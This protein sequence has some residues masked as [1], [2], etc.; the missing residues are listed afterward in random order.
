MAVAVGAVGAVSQGAVSRRGSVARKAEARAAFCEGREFDEGT[1][2]EG[3]HV[4]GCH[5]SV[6]NLSLSSTSTSSAQKCPAKWL[7]WPVGAGHSTCRL[8]GHATRALGWSAAGIGTGGGMALSGSGSSSTRLWHSLSSAAAPSRPAPTSF[9]QRPSGASSLSSVGT[10]CPQHRHRNTL[11]PMPQRLRS[12]HARSSCTRRAQ[13]LQ[14]WTP[15]AVK[16]GSLLAIRLSA[17]TPHTVQR[18]RSESCIGFS[19]AATSGAQTGQISSRS[20]SVVG[21]IP[22]PI[23]E[24]IFI[25]TREK[26]TA[27]AVKPFSCPTRVKRPR[28][29]RDQPPPE[30]VPRHVSCSLITRT[31][32]EQRSPQGQKRRACALPSILLLAVHLQQ[33]AFPKQEVLDLSPRS[34]AQHIAPPSS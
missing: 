8:D 6:S 17:G 28:P 32:N 18:S 25:E 3:G 4:P 2:G 15:R 10:A 5:E 29:S 7:A 26:N 19:G 27:P 23:M 21:P 9:S 16:Y 34:H 14:T 31:M 13:L 20:S 11:R 30:A 12:C 1:S 24:A 22:M 33:F